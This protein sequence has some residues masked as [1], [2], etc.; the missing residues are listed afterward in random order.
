MKRVDLISF[1]LE[2]QA[3][4]KKLGLSAHDVRRMRT[5]DESRTESK[6]ALLK[7]I[8]ENEKQRGLEPW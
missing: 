3:R 4:F 8:R 2:A 6:K 7:I 5:P 1:G